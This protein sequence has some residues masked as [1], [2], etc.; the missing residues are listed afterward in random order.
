M[1]MVAANEVDPTA[2]TIEPLADPAARLLGPEPPG[3]ADWL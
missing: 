3:A 1:I 2:I